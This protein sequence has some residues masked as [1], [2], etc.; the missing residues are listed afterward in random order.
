M[1]VAITGISGFIGTHLK[2][3]LSIQ[4]GIEILAIGKQEFKSETVLENIVKKSDVIVHLA[5]VNRHEDPNE[6]VGTNISLLERLIRICINTQSKPYIIFSSS[7]QEEIDNPYGRSKKAGQEMLEDWARKY[8]GTYAGLVIPNV[9]GPFGKPFYNS[10]VATFCHQLAHGEIPSIHEDKEIQLIYVNALVSR[11]WELINHPQFGRIKIDHQVQIKVSDLLEKLKLYAQ[12]YIHKGELPSLDSTFHLA[13]FN[14]F[15]CYLPIDL[16][17]LA[18]RKNEDSRG[19][20][21]EIMRNNSGGQFSYSTTKPGITRGNHYHT[22]KAERFAVI[23]GEAL[24]K[25][26]RIDESEIIEYHI[27]GDLPAFVDMPVWHTHNITNVGNEE[28]ITLFW[29]NE[30][31]DPGN[32]DTYFLDV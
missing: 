6:L 29:I 26:R 15:R 9:F 11:I 7:L 13:L 10:V 31:Y 22:R 14:T 1:R 4:P 12:Q 27:N 25:L 18:Y 5:A 23:R 8:T 3:F 16:F 28:L 17:P 20:F 19:I 30:P 24:I 21:V 32:S 2:N